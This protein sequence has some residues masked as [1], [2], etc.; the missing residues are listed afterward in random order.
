[1]GRAD[2]DFWQLDSAGS[3]R[4]LDVTSVFNFVS[5]C[6]ALSVPCGWTTEDDLPMGLQIIG[7]RFEDLG[8]LRIAAAFEMH[9][10]WAHRRPPL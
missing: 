5:Q 8:P 1:V 9:R 7:R 10:P 4:C 6:P 2:T 3:Y